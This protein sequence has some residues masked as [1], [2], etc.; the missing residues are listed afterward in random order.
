MYDLEGGAAMHIY[1]SLSEVV[2]RAFGSL[3]PVEHYHERW[4]VGSNI[5]KPAPGQL[6]NELA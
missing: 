4:I 3:M 1:P 2:Q 6:G 5:F